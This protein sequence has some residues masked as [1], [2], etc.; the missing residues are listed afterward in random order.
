M[1]K[2]FKNMALDQVDVDKEVE[3]EVKKKDEMSFWEHLNELRARIIRALIAITVGVIIV[4]AMGEWFFDMII[5]APINKDFPTYKFMCDLA[6]QTGMK[7]LCLAPPSLTLFTTEIGE[8]F[9]KHMQVAMIIGLLGAIPV[10]FWQFWLFIKPGLMEE[11]VKAARGFVTICSSLFIAGVMFGYFIITPFAVSFLANYK[12]AGVGGTASLD[13][14]IGYLTMFT[15]PIGL[16]F[17]LP[18]IIFFLARIGIVSSKMLSQYRKHMVVVLLL[19]SGIITPSPDVVSQLLV[20]VPLYLLFEV[21][22]LVSK[23]VEKK[24]ALNNG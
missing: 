24:R 7:D 14:Y 3:Y 2:K 5:Y 18:V 10:V 20:F 12:M 17:E 19:A 13:S 21:G 8:V 22:I 23:R 4:F 9:F 15:L 16:V 11:E 6:Q 1:D